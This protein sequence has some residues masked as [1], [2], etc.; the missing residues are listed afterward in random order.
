M[1]AVL[2]ILTCSVFL[3]ACKSNLDDSNTNNSVEQD[4]VE[5]ELY[6][7]AIS[8][9]EDG[10][11]HVL[12]T[13][14]DSSLI[15][16]THGPII[17]YNTRLL[18]SNNQDQPSW[19]EIDTVD[20]VPMKLKAAPEGIEQEDKRINLLLSLTDTTGQILEKFTEKYVDE[21]IAIVIGGDAVTIHKIREKI[22]GGKLQITRC[23]DNACEK[24]LIELED[25]VVQ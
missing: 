17:F 10:I 12:K 16:E 20:F 2:I 1:R 22:I 19:F 9:P 21:R 7:L 8:H 25:N 14:E 4:S 3:N 11:Y 5:K 13:Y 24:L 18:D 15:P 23:T 6:S